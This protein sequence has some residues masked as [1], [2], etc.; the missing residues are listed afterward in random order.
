MTF[1]RTRASRR[2]A[3][4][5]LTLAV[6]V[7]GFAGTGCNTKEQAVRSLIL[8]NQERARQGV[9]PLYWNDEAA[10]KAEAWAAKLAAEGGLEHSQLENGIATEWR[11]LGEN[12]G[13]GSNVDRVHRSFMRSGSHRSTLLSG[14]Y[15]EMGVG[16]AYGDGVVYITQVFRG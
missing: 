1:A 15:R 10:A 14:K 3:A 4:A 9:P 5:V 16:V 8:V 6:L 11:Y 12:V 7:I 2:T 13:F